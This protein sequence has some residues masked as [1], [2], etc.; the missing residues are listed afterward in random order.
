MD[1][2]E[3]I[4]IQSLQVLADKTDALIQ[5]QLQKA[6]YDKTYNGIITAVK[7][8]SNTKPTDGNYNKYTVK[9]NL[10]ERDF[11]I[12]DGQFHSVGERVKVHIPNN[13]TINKYVETNVDGS[14]AL[15]VT[16]VYDN[17]NDTITEVY[18]GDLQRKFALTIENK[19]TEDESTKQMTFPD[20][21]VVSFV[22]F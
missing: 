1:N 9:F 13:N 15:P 4:M 8:D 11:I 5:S 12:N 20:G 19:G 16:I 17:E 7:F 2:T 18:N 10:I 6:S 3:N 21:S 14:R 22:G